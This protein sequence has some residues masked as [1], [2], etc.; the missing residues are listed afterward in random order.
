MPWLST[1]KL[2]WGPDARVLNISSTGLLLESG[3]K[4]TP[5]STAEL[6]LSGPDWQIAIP[7]CFVRSEVGPVN[8]QGVKYH[9]AAEFETPLEFP[10][11]PQ[12]SSAAPALPATTLSAGTTKE[13]KRAELRKRAR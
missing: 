1:V 5:G 8:G 12:L 11:T 9:I 13:A 7:A 10:A 6:K 2:P 3:S 4:V